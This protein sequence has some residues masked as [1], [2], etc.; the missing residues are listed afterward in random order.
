MDVDVPVDENP[1]QSG[2]FPVTELP[3]EFLLGSITTNALLKEEK[4]VQIRSSARV[5]KKMKLEQEQ[6]KKVGKQRQVYSVLLN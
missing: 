1:K 3:D 6:D 2:D 4:G 5:F